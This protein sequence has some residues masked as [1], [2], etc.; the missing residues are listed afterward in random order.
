MC[1]G[2][3]AGG[4]GSRAGCA[5]PG[6]KR[7]LR[8]SLRG[9]QERPASLPD[10]ARLGTAVSLPRKSW[11]EGRGHHRTLSRT[12][13]P[14]P[15][16]AH[17]ALL[18]LRPA[19][20]AGGSP[21]A[22]RPAT[23]APWSFPQERFRLGPNGPVVT[24]QE[25]F[26]RLGVRLQFPQLPCLMMQ[27][28]LPCWVPMELCSFLPGQ[29]AVRA[30]APPGFQ[31]RGQCAAARQRGRRRRLT[32]PLVFVSACPP[33]HR[34]GT[35]LRRGAGAQHGRGRLAGGTPLRR[36]GRRNGRGGRRD[37]PKLRRPGLRQIP[38]GQPLC[39]AG[40]PSA[41]GAGYYA[42]NRAPQLGPA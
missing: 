32:A 22:T 3:A 40:A 15:P 31:T 38:Q 26:A 42:P 16:P 18:A 14:P 6:P 5:A 12:G 7:A 30:G 9:R 25:H 29:V 2:A 33:G 13:A 27:G 23:G 1:R 21:H 41:S 39:R 37:R 11:A 34:T 24:V 4:P 10:R 17:P 28:Q 8:R 35:M 20:I 36:G 19:G